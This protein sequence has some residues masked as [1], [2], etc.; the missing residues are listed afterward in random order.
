[1]LKILIPIFKYGLIADFHR[2]AALLLLQ[3][4]PCMWIL[5]PWH[6]E[7]RHQIFGSWYPFTQSV[8]FRQQFRPFMFKDTV[9]NEYLA[10]SLLYIDYYSVSWNLLCNFIRRCLPLHPFMM[11]SVLLFLCDTF[12]V[13][14]YEV[15]LV[16][17]VFFKFCFFWYVLTYHH[18]WFK[19]SLN[20]VNSRGS[21]VSFRIY[22]VIH[23]PWGFF[24]YSNLYS[25]Y[26]FTLLFS[27]IQFHRDIS[28][29]Q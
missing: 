13:I 12:V 24:F 21:V 27:I 8:S 15:A 3:V 28:L 19:A 26:Y 6:Q 16:V 4:H 17:T 9:D 22:T 10:L 20:I 29:T 2:I 7:W 25:C 18:L 5:S 1:M 11:L 14:F 23:D